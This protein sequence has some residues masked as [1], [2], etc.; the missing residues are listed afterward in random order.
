[1][2]FKLFWIIEKFIFLVPTA[3]IKIWL[4]LWIMLPSFHVYI[5]PLLL[6]GRVLY[7]QSAKRQTRSFR[8]R[9]PQS[10]QLPR[11]QN[12]NSRFLNQHLGLQQLQTLRAH[13]HAQALQGAS[14]C[15][16]WG[17]GQGN[18][19]EEENYRG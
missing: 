13:R 5:L 17:F 10:T 4:G 18:G 15:A 16:F 12:P 7:V 11:H 19:A 9:N 2:F 1:M 14:G 6:P 8:E 3:P